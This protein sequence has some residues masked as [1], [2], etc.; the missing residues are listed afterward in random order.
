M[1]RGTAAEWT[2]ADPTLANG[3]WGL[4]TDTGKFKIGTGSAAWEDNGFDYSS[5]PSTAITTT[6]IDAVGDIFIGTADNVAG[7]LAVGTNDYVLTADSSVSNVG[8]AWKVTGTPALI[9][10]SAN[11]S[12]NETTYPTFVD[13]AT[14]AQG[15]ETDTGLT[16]NPSTGTLTSTIFAGNATTSTE[17]TTVTA[18]ANNS[19]NETTYL[20]FVDGATNAQG[21]ETDTGLT[22]NPS[23]GTLTSTIFAGAATTAGTV[24]TATQSAITSVGTLGSLAV[25]GAVTAGS[26]VAPL[27]INTPTASYTL[28][29]ADAG[30]LIE[31][32]VGSTNT[33]TVPT[34]SGDGN[35]VAFATG[36]QIVVVQLGAGVTTIAGASGVGLN[37]KDD[38]KVIDGQYAA[39]TLIKKGTNDWW[40]FGALTS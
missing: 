8:L 39:V 26:L 21:I 22:Y 5:L 2:A 11:N 27:A 4:E 7:R 33:L 19:T 40:L 32:N 31:M 3:E 10:A 6:V 16:Y 38:N 24:T 18:T 12:T 9:T 35:S 23:T 14:G 34:H 29:A 20:T 17:A 36:T 25:T 30:K 13:G 37:S 15:I 1:R 28:V